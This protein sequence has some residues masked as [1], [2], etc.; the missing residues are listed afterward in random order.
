MRGKRQEELVKVWAQS[1]PTL[2]V[3]NLLKVWFEKSNFVL[4]AFN[5]I[6]CQPLFQ[7]KTKSFHVGLKILNR[8]RELI[9]IVLFVIKH[10]TLIKWIHP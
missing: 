10:A 5:P 3:V 2:A 8:Q 1:L 6:Y 9:E 7:L 4:E